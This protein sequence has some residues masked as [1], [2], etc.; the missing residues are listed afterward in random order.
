MNLQIFHQITQRWEVPEI[1]LLATRFSAEMGT[2]GSLYQEDK[3]LALD[4]LSISW[5]FRLACIS[6]LFP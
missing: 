6:L 1:Q 2:F 4:V 5:R 3:P